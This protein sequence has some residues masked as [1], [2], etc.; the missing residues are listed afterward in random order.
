M[1]NLFNQINFDHDTKKYRI[2]INENSKW[3]TELKT[4]INSETGKPYERYITI[5]ESDPTKGYGYKRGHTIIY[6]NIHN[7]IPCAWHNSADYIKLETSNTITLNEPI[8]KFSYLIQDGFPWV[9]FDF[10]D[11]DVQ[12]DSY[13]PK[14]LFD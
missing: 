4:L 5:I 12:K 9:S 6:K 13:E 3:T 14:D 11:F 10:I 2:E 7:S 8:L 1:N